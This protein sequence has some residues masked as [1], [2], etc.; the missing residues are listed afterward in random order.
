M[1]NEESVDLKQLM[2]LLDGGSTSGEIATQLKVTPAFIQKK[3]A[4]LISA[5]PIIEEYRR[6]QHLQLTELQA[7]IL[8][9]IT[10]E[11]LVGASL[12]DLVAAFKTLKENE[13]LANGK[14]TEIKGLVAY[15]IHLEREAVSISRPSFVDTTAVEVPRPSE[16]VPQF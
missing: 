13:L 12:R 8:E 3:T 14:P 6:V 7:N 1:D 4:E 16:G 15:L 9:N 10:E 2:Q 11:K 5:E